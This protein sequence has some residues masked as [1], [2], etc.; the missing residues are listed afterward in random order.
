[1]SEPPLSRTIV[2]FRSRF[3]I[4]GIMSVALITPPEASV[5]TYKFQLVAFVGVVL[6]RVTSVKSVPSV[7]HAMRFLFTV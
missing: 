5:A 7:F 2:V 4:R 6:L 3:L 1:M